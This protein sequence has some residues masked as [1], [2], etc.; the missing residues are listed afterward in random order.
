MKI[1]QKYTDRVPVRFFVSSSYLLHDIGLDVVDVVTT[2][3]WKVLEHGMDV[4]S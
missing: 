2:S 1:R 3:Q 4:E